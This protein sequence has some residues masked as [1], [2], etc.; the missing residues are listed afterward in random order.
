M[1]QFVVVNGRWTH[2]VFYPLENAAYMKAVMPSDLQLKDV[3]Q[4]E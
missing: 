3:I 1:G 4:N 2:F